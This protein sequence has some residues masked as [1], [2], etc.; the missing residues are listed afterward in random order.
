MKNKILYKIEAIC[1][2]FILLIS[3]VSIIR[4]DASE[5]DLLTD[6]S[7]NEKVN[8]SELFEMGG[9][10]AESLDIDDETN[11]FIYADDTDNET[12]ED[13]T[14][15]S[16]VSE[17]N[18]EGNVY[19]N[20]QYAQEIENESSG[21][22]VN[23][24]MSESEKGDKA[25]SWRFTDGEKIIQDDKGISLY[26][27]FIPWSKTNGYFINN[28]GEKI[29][30]A[31]RKGID[32]SKW[33]EEINWNQVKTTDV[34][35]AIIRCG[36]GQDYSSQDDPY[37]K[38]NADACE[39]LGI[40]F[41]TYLYSYATT[42]DAAKSEAQHVLRLVEGY[43]LDYPIFYDLEEQSV[44]DK[45]SK[46]E[47][48]AIAQTFCDTI[49]SAGYDV[50]IYANKDWFTNYL[51]DSRFDQWDKWV[52]QYNSRCTYDGEY[53][54]WQC[55]D[56]GTV[57]GINGVV[58]INFE[59]G[60]ESEP[61]LVIIDGNT[62]CYIGDVQ[63]FGEQKVNG[64]W[65]YFDPDTGIMKTGFCDLGTKTV[66]YGSDGAMKYGEQKINN[67]W[68]YFNTV[69]GAM[70]TGFCN[71]GNKIVYYSSDGTMCYGE[72]IINGKIYYF[73][74]VTGAMKT[75]WSTRN[76]LKVYYKSDGSLATGEQKINNK[77]Y[78]FDEENGEMIVGWYD[79]GNKIVYYGS[80]GAMCY[81]ERKIDGKWYYFNTVTGAMTVGFCNLSSKKVYYGPD[82]AMR[83]GEQK[84]DGKWYYFDIVTGAMATGFYDLGTKIVYYGSNGAMCYGEQKIDGKWYYF[85]TVTGAMNI[86]FCDLGSKIVYYGPDGAMRYGEQKIDGRWYH[87]NTVTGAMSTGFYN[88]GSK[89]V[90]YGSDGTMR[91]GSQMINGKWYYFDTVTGAMQ[92]NK[93][94]NGYYY[95]SD[96]TRQ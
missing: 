54:M 68:Y 88:L 76:G 74:T 20:S 23:N 61:E 82:G 64:K 39:K 69:T 12:V 72:Q 30:G 85:N 78:C 45:L 60:A 4:V 19:N 11:D 77:W 21:K 26:S 95:G 14:E 28:L 1:I 57:N 79:L 5:S 80:D 22:T 93:T 81:G 48:A 62:Y 15:N 92:K 43:D 94:I 46:T 73:D 42:V 84:I 27:D 66:Y 51:T 71:L 24:D 56:S 49:E 36:Y 40:P 32:V 86:G 8:N 90:Y 70:T 16:G 75:G 18:D 38:T 55:T 34:D 35:Y 17:N 89:I 9:D 50:A 52:A 25:N 29:E 58:D 96:G 47:I 7:K 31:V 2:I 44:R 91:Y 67:K 3:N 13:M 59:F 33:N 37:W 65:Y 53:I 6:D 63:V 41:G 10:A 83:Y 87:F